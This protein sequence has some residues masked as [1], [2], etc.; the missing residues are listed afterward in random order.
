MSW[1]WDYLWP[2]L[3]RERERRLSRLTS[4]NSISI[5]QAFESS[6]S[7]TVQSN[8]CHRIPSTTNWI[9]W[10]LSLNLVFNYFIASFIAIFEWWLSYRCLSHSTDLQCI[11]PSVR[12]PVTRIPNLFLHQPQPPPAGLSKLH[13]TTNHLMVTLLTIRLCAVLTLKLSKSLEVLKKRRDGTDTSSSIAIM[14]QHSLG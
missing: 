7:P 12:Q 10:K 9:L 4:T 6:P 14:W 11:R 13:Q 5:R 1:T 3:E 2:W 8:V